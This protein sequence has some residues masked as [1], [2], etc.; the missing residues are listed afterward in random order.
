MHDGLVQD[1]LMLMLRRIV[2]GL[3]L[4]R[5]MMLL[6]LR[7]VLLRVMMV[8]QVVVLPLRRHA[9]RNR[10][11]SSCELSLETWYLTR[12]AL[13]GTLFYSPTYRFSFYADLTR[14]IFR[15]FTDLGR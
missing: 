10:G 6:R 13:I 7:V 2:M 8:G 9:H 15:I 14:L 4:L 3:L 12:V 11:P 1:D 5:L